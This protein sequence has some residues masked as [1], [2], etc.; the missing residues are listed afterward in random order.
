M[1]ELRHPIWASLFCA[2]LTLLLTG[3]NDSELRERVAT[4]ESR[5]VVPAEKPKDSVRLPA[6]A[7]PIRYN[8][9]SETALDKW[10][11]GMKVLEANV[12]A[13]SAFLAQMQE[14]GDLLLQGHGDFIGS[15]SG[16]LTEQGF[17]RIAGSNT[18]EKIIASK[19]VP[20]L[21]KA[22]FE[23]LNQSGDSILSDF[24]TLAI[25]GPGEIIFRQTI[26]VR[27][28]S[29]TTGNMLDFA[30]NESEPV[31]ALFVEAGGIPVQGTAE[32]GLKEPLSYLRGG[33]INVDSDGRVKINGRILRGVEKKVPSGS[34]HLSISP[35]GV[36]SAYDVSGNPAELGQIV[37]KQIKKFKNDPK[38]TWVPQP[39]DGS[40]ETYK[41]DGRM[42]IKIGVLEYPGDEEDSL[43]LYKNLR[44][45][46]ALQALQAGLNS[47][48]KKSEAPAESDA[49]P[50]IVHSPLPKT[51]EHL[52]ALKI[53]AEKTNERTTIGT[54]ADETDVANALVTVLQGLRRR[55]TVHEENLRNAGK[56]RDSEGRLNAYRR[57]TVS[58]GPQG[59]IIEGVDK[60]DLPKNYKPGDPDA[61]PDGFVMLSNVNKAVESAEFKATI[62]EY[63]LLR[64]ALERL[65]PKHIFPDPPSVP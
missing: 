1:S 50:L 28:S 10:T 14:N 53:S 9:H 6:N 30:L 47:A 51:T 41:S 25:A 40:I 46:S 17:K 12:T 3:C 7:A 60:S 20:K 44:I 42:P 5:L 62:E 64:T 36:V 19:D 27:G 38:I 34:T 37:I 52:N 24:M 32:L 13:P 26:P 23:K 45:R 49:L 63:K 58:I 57:K 61:G 33:R 15:A 54:G 56:T 2:A 39:D 35:E 43:S 8:T 18:W 4:V 55:M 11:L 48:S 16:W 22:I 29:V 21:E 65:A 31:P 59:N